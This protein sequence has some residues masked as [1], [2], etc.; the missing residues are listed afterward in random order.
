MIGEVKRGKDF[1]GLGG[2]LLFGRPP[3]NDTGL[4]DYLLDGKAEGRERV[5]WAEVRNLPPEH[6]QHAGLLMQATAAQ[7]HRVEQ[8]VYHLILSADPGETL[9]RED[10]RHVVDRVLRNLGLTEH[11]AL[12]VAHRDTAHRHVHLM[13]NTVHP[14]RLKVW[15]NWNDYARI[16][17][18]LRHL[19]RE[20]GLREVPGRHYQLPGQ[21]RPERTV[22]ATSGERR[23]RDRTGEATWAEQVRFRVYNVLRDSKSWAELER[24]L[25]RH[26]L[27]LERRGGGLVVTD[28]RR[29]IKSSRIYRRGSY[30]GLEKRFGLSFEE[31]RGQ[32]RGLLDA[33]DRYQQA[34]RRSRDLEARRDRARRTVQRAERQVEERVQSRTAT[35]HN[36]EELRRAL[37]AI[38]GPAEAP[39]AQKKLARR[40]HEVG[41]KQAGQ[42]IRQNLARFGRLQL[43]RLAR[44]TPTGRR[45]LQSLAWHLGKS[46]A[47]RSVLLAA[48]AVAGPVGHRAASK[49]LFA[50]GVYLRAQ[51]RFDKMPTQALLRDVAVRAGVLGLNVVKLAVAPNPWSV[52]RAA[53]RTA[54]LVQSTSRALGR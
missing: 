37:T 2:Y 48:R 44:L 27:R 33:V 35:R 51:S 38:Y 14:E 25:A 24:G 50:R 20:M 28:G 9:S 46:A 42:E 16:E 29:R 30:R 5:A 54:Q 21:E 12:V 3:A 41:W 15:N 19:E 1:G 6:L 11:Q 10:W 22:G 18:T 39:Q 32:R 31:W 53:V 36:A 8:P 7:N 34:E 45:L 26:D 47:E 13:V 23:E 4:Q 49:L 40:A 52:V 17:K 43:G